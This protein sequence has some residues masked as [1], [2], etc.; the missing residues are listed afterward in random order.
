M[1]FKLLIT[2]LHPA[3]ISISVILLLGKIFV[4]LWNSFAIYFL[5]RFFNA[6]TLP[7][8]MFKWFALWFFPSRQNLYSH[9]NFLHLK[10]LP[11]NPET[12][13]PVLDESTVCQWL[14][15]LPV[16]DGWYFKKWK[17]FWHFSWLKNAVVPE[18]EAMIKRCSP[19]HQLLYRSVIG[20]MVNQTKPYC[21][22]PAMD[23]TRPQSTCRLNEAY[24]CYLS[25]FPYMSG[26][27]VPQE[28]L[29]R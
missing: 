25:V 18:T 20:V 12:F 17:I 7:D 6:P 9:Q 14:T 11:H 2:R 22:Q 29:C 16:N 8:Y 1:F 27:N 21:D 24:G 15:L 23:T 28:K 5:S 4:P 3:Y 10:W 13:S 19:A 26:V